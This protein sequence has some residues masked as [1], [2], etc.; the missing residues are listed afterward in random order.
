[1]FCLTKY[2]LDADLYN[3]CNIIVINLFYIILFKYLNKI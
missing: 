3:G 1:M 2:E